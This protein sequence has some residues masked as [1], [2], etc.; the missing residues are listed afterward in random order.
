MSVND[1]KIFTM[2]DPGL[3]LLNVMQTN[4]S[5][6]DD[7]IL[8]FRRSAEENYVDPLDD[9]DVN[10]VRSSRFDVLT[11][12][13]QERERNIKTKESASTCQRLILVLPLS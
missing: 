6:G 9:D 1:V 10:N 3:V 2:I 12:R 8:I 4:V 7:F 5:V 13:P 11:R